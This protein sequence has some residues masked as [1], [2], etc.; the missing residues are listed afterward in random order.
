MSLYAG[1]FHHAQNFLL[2]LFAMGANETGRPPVP[3]GFVLSNLG[4][5]MEWRSRLQAT[6]RH[7]SAATGAHCTVNCETTHW[8][9][10]QAE[11]DGDSSTSRLR[12]WCSKSKYNIQSAK[13]IYALLYFGF[14]RALVLDAEARLVKPVSLHR[15]FDLSLTA[16]S[17]WW[18]P[19][20]PH[21]HSPTMATMLR[22]ALLLLRGRDVYYS[23][24]VAGIFESLALPANSS[25]L[26]VQHWFYDYEWVLALARRIESLHGTLTRGICEGP[27]TWE[28]IVAFAF[29][30]NY[31][32]H[33]GD[34]HQATEAFAPRI[35]PANCYP[36]YNAES[37]L[38]R[39]GLGK[40]VVRCKSTSGLHVRAS[41]PCRRL[42][43]FCWK[44]WMRTTRKGWTG[45]D[46]S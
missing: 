12:A 11:R 9:V 18:A 8:E 19:G 32:R 6:R 7:Y 24:K 36:F 31:S 16:P 34:A 33:L 1:H 14:G 40:H 37:E 42:G 22:K 35:T 21:R 46:N 13:K 27:S 5:E 45:C 28:A 10:V 43:S 17:F 23:T 4:E 44:G 25:F 41:D 30:Y 2:T 39:F 38:Q 15:L 29:L 3:I 26:S 20:A